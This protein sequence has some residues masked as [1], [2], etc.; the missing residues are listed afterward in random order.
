M[1]MMLSGLLPLLLVAIPARAEEAKEARALVEKVVAAAGGK[2]KLPRLA[3]VT[4][5]GQGSA[6]IKEKKFSLRDEWSAREIGLWRWNL[7]AEADGRNI[8]ILLVANRDKVWAQGDGP[9]VAELPGDI[10]HS[11]Q[12]AARV[13]RLVERPD[14]LLD[15]GCTLS[16]LGELKIETREAVGVKVVVKGQPDVDLFFDKK[17]LAPLRAEIR[18]KESKD[19]EEVQYRFSFDGHK[20]FGDVSHFTKVSFHRNETLHLELELSEVKPVETIDDSTFEKP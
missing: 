5:Q 2:E 6:Y 19:G 10:V 1:R 16:S 20:K 11:L 12:A 4:W 17:T 15:K 9:K 13:V 3:A 18:N 8:T 7:N 14:L